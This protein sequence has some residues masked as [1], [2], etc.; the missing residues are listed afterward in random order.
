MIELAIRDLRAG[1]GAVEVLHGVDLEVPAGAL[2]AL[3]GPNGAGKTTLL[4]VVAG[5][6]P[7][8]SGR[9]S[10]AGHDIAHVPP[11]ERARAGRLDPAD[12][13]AA[14]RVRPSLPI[15]ETAAH[16]ELA[17]VEGVGRHVEVGFEP[18]IDPLIAPVVDSRIVATRAS[19]PPGPPG[20]GR[21]PS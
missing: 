17:G 15:P 4:S 10:W 9:V 1:Y 6:L 7:L 5:L 20:R 18:P 19:P 12:H 11:D 8:G 3:L 13:A 14:A 21:N 16:R 2:T